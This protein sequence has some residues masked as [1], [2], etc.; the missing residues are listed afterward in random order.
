MHRWYLA[1]EAFT[2][3]VVEVEEVLAALQQDLTHMASS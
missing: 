2:G 3:S 1:D